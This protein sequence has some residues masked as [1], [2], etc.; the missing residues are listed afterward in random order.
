[1]EETRFTG[2]PELLAGHGEEPGDL[3]GCM[4]VG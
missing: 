1:M 4:T 3:E 2:E